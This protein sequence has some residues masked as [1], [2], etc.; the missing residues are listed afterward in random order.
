MSYEIN[1][2]STGYTVVVDGKL[3]GSR[4]TLNEAEHIGRM[5]TDE[6]YRRTYELMRKSPKFA[7]ET[8]QRALGRKEPKH[9][10]RLGP[11]ILRYTS[12]RGYKG[13]VSEFYLS[14][15]HAQR[16]WGDAWRWELMRCLKGLQ[17]HLKEAEDEDAQQVVFE[18]AQALRR[19]DKVTY[20]G[21]LLDLIRIY[22][23]LY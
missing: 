2:A 6:D 13:D 17:R 3:R 18:M 12:G 20:D 19:Q 4:L 8:M 10:A 9:Y 1:K 14:W 21:H 23:E 15:E 5:H 11:H 7:V 22:G 16:T